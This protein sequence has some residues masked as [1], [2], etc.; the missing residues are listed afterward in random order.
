MNGDR[1]PQ[2][3]SSDSES[4]KASPLQVAATIFWALFAIGKRGTWEKGGTTI[5]LRQ[6]V[7]G[8]FAGLLVV[9]VLLVLLVRAIVR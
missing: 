7:I 6:A 1:Q 9:V 4:H 8:A 3:G 2:D 5:T